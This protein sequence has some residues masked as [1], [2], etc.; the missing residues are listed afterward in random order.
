[1]IYFISDGRGSIKIGMSSD[2]NSRL[3]QLQCAS[4]TRLSVIGCMS[5]DSKSEAKLHR[6]FND[7]RVNGEWF[8]FVGKL[9]LFIYGMIQL[10]TMDFVISTQEESQ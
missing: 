4:P 2:V 7:L 8:S 10:R 3:A 1:M 9:R 6:I 5:G